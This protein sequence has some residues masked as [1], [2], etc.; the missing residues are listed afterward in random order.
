MGVQRR[1][2]R[3]RH[4]TQQ[5]AWHLYAR[6][7]E[8]YYLG[9]FQEAV[10]LYGRLDRVFPARQQVEARLYEI[11]CAQADFH[12][13]LQHWRRYL[14]TQPQAPNACEALVL[15]ELQLQEADYE[16]A[17]GSLAGA[18]HSPWP[19]YRLPYYQGLCHLSQGVRREA[20]RCFAAATSMI[21]PDLVTLRFEELYRVAQGL[22]SPLRPRHPSLSTPSAK[23]IETRTMS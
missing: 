17:A 22:A 7:E 4:T 23:T 5:D 16:G 13:A 9:Q 6:A 2:Y 12:L 11:A 1:W 14:E 15:A 18:T 20:R 8:A 21:N 3:L 10:R 19:D